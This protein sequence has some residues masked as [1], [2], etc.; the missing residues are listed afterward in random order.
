MKTI[1]FNVAKGEAQ[2][3]YVGSYP[4]NVADRMIA[5]GYAEEVKAEPSQKTSSVAS[6]TEEKKTTKPFFSKKE[7]EEK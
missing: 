2:K 6:T 1:K 7:G 4:D 3:G 5:E